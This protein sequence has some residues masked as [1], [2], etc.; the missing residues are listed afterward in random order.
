MMARRMNE[1]LKNV[2]TCY[3]ASITGFGVLLCVD[4]WIWRVATDIYFV[5]LVEMA[6]IRS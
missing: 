4:N 5:Y 6:S 2:H 1:R 3:V